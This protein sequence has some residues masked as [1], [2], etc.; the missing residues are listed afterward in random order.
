[1]STVAASGAVELAAGADCVWPA[2]RVRQPRRERERRRA[3]LSSSFLSLSNVAE[4]PPATAAAMRPSGVAQSAATPSVQPNLINM[5][6]SGRRVCRRAASCSRSSNEA[7]ERRARPGIQSN[8]DNLPRARPAH[9]SHIARP[10]PLPT[11]PH[12]GPPASRSSRNVEPARRL[13]SL[14]CPGH[15]TPPSAPQPRGRPA[16]EETAARRAAPAVEKTC[17]RRPFC[18]Q[19]ALD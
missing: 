8:C 6:Q 19:T 13:F 4:L 14:D 1:M 11:G 10:P 3:M 18:R 7:N 17:R 12:T 9:S 16:R 5:F 15:A 2:R